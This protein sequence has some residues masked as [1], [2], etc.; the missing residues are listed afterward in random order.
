MNPPIPNIYKNDDIDIDNYTQAIHDNEIDKEN[1]GKTFEEVLTLLYSVHVKYVNELK[2]KYD[3]K[4]NYQKHLSDYSIQQLEL[5]NKK[6]NLKIEQLEKQI[7]YHE[8]E[9]MKI[10]NDMKIVFE[11][12]LKHWQQQYHILKKHFRNYQV[13]AKERIDQWKKYSEYI[14]FENQ[15]LQ[16]EI[17]AKL[18]D[19]SRNNIDVSM[20]MEIP[21]EKEQNIINTNT[22]DN[23]TK[24]IYK[25]KLK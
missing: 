10:N 7:Q 13:K 22:I 1:E 4:L 3:H 8:E 25:K 17:I 11:K 23:V 2:T 12:E 14:K 24:I 20:L 21:S 15:K 6:L 19:I 16:N 18:P 9:P 5:D